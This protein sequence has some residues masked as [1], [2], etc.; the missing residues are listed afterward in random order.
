MKMNFSYL[1]RLVSGMKS[2]YL[3]NR[4]FRELNSGENNK[5]KITIEKILHLPIKIHAEVLLLYGVVS[6]RLRDYKKATLCLSKFRE[7]IQLSTI[8][9]PQEKNYLNCYGDI[10]L[11][12][13]KEHYSAADSL[14]NYGDSDF[15]IFDMVD[16]VIIHNW[17]QELVITKVEI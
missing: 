11:T 5:A 7:Y 14:D 3:A 2:V 10:L 4:A 12:N 17:P 6:F 1:K 16:P 13:I 15:L 9:N 8:H